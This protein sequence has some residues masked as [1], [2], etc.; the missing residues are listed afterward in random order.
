[1]LII[2]SGLPG[3]GKSTIA[4]A[5]AEELHA[6]YVRADSIEQQ[7]RSS[8]LKLKSID[9]L[10]YLAGH[11]VAEDNLR[12]GHTVIADSVNPWALTRQGWRDVAARASV[13]SFDVEIICSDPDEHRRRVETRHVNIPGLVLPTWQQVQERD[14]HPWDT[15]RLVIDTSQRSAEDCVREIRGALG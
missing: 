1:M 15:P 12:L 13:R 10:G 3:T 2:F 11:A 14:Y 7:L 8:V 9:D 5:L 6:A 4:H